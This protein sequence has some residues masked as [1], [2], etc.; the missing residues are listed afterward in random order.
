MIAMALGNIMGGR[1]ADRNPNPDKLYG[2]L[3]DSNSWGEL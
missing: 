2:S 1:W 3:L